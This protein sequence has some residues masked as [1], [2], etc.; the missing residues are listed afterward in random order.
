MSILHKDIL[1]PGPEPLAQPDRERLLEV[2][3]MG[4]CMQ[5]CIPEASASREKSNRAISEAARLVSEMTCLEKTHA[6]QYRAA[7]RALSEQA[8]SVCSFR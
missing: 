5:L 4:P 3:Q 2:L 1:M 6:S 7:G 8:S